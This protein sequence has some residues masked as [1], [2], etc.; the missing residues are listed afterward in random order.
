MGGTAGKLG[1]T[2]TA[3]LVVWAGPKF[4][5]VGRGAGAPPCSILRQG[6]EHKV[7]VLGHFHWPLLMLRK[8]EMNMAYGSWVFGTRVKQ[9]RI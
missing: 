2:L 6:G 9:E 4:K 1:A 5:F 7:T 3:R 8:N